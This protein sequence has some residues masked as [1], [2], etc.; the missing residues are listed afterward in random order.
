MPRRSIAVY[1][2]TKDRPP[3]QTSASHGTVYY[4]RPLA[5]NIQPGH[6]L[7]SE[8]VLEL[9]TLIARR[10]KQIEFL[11]HRELEFSEAIEAIT[12]SPSFRL[13]RALTWPLRALRKK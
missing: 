2:Y 13:G 5:S 6:T 9:E 7:T 11:Y 12:K 4:Q 8:D 1:F 3:E 10:D